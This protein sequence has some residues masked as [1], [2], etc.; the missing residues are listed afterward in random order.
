MLVTVD[1]AFVDGWA[2]RYV[3]FMG[4]EEP[5][6]LNEVGPRVRQQGY[7]TREDL[8]AVGNWKSVRIRSRLA[9][10]S[11]EDIRDITTLAFGAPERLQHS[12]L[13]LLMGVQVRAASAFLTIWEPTRHTVIDVRSL[14]A[15]HA[16]G[17]IETTSLA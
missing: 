4:S 10:N 16:L 14:N 8:A 9:S 2:N 15:L 13:T 7:Y 3:R 6:L 17:E 12:I 5:R 1:S 11:D